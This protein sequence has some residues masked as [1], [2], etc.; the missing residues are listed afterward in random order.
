MLNHYLEKINRDCRNW[1]CNGFKVI[2]C[3]R[4]IRHTPIP[5]YDY[6][7][8]RFVWPHDHHCLIDWCLSKN[9][10]CGKPVAESFCKRQGYMHA[11]SFKKKSHVSST[12]TLGSQELCRG[13]EC[14][15]FEE[16]IC[17]R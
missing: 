15:G 10:D 3:V 2:R 9:K 5:P 11:K 17:Y 14:S 4:A 6:R 7:E 12:R 1:R 8:R 16:L 13:N